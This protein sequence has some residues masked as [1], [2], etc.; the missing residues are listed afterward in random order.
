MNKEFELLPECPFCLDFKKNQ[1]IC[2]GVN[3]HSEAVLKFSRTRFMKEYQEGY[4]CS[5]NFGK[6]PVAKMLYSKYED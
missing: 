4:C 5:M 6:C 3:D 2:E 1:I